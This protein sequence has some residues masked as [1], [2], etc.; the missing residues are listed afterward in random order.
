MAAV[1]I[2]EVQLLRQVVKH[3]LLVVQRMAV[4]PRVTMVLQEVL[5]VPLTIQVHQVQE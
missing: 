5:V 2:L 4:R 3:L 1:N